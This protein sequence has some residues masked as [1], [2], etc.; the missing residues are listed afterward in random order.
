M[1]D[2]SDSMRKAL[3]HIKSAIALDN[4][5]PTRYAEAIQLYGK[6]IECFM[7]VVEMKHEGKKKIISAQMKRYRERAEVLK[8]YKSGIADAGKSGVGEGL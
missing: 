6:G 3:E 8:T 4:E 2:I 1:A 5:G 7:H